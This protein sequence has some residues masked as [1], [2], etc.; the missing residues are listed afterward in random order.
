MPK[1]DATRPYVVM[2]NIHGAT[3]ALH[4]VYGIRYNLKFST[5]G[6]VIVFAQ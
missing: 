5:V 2:G 6:E 4:A 3:L 1:C